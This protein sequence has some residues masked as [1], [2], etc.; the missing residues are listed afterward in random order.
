MAMA[1]GNS[2]NTSHSH[3]EAISSVTGLLTQLA[4]SLKINVWYENMDN[5]F[6]VRVFS[7]INI[8]TRVTR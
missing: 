5:L 2:G 7:E 1:G 8:F 3:C 4:R 6:F